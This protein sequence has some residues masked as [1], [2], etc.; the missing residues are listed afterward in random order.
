MKNMASIME[1]WS[2]S[3]SVYR[4]LK[5]QDTSWLLWLLTLLLLN[6]LGGLA[7]LD[8]LFNLGSEQVGLACDQE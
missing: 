1:L 4:A 7:A 3:Q 2:K 5:E 8:P 6:V